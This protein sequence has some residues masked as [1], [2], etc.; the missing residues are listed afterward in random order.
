MGERHLDAIYLLDLDIFRKNRN[1]AISGGENRNFWDISIKIVY[2]YCISCEKH[3]YNVYLTEKPQER[4]PYESHNR[5][6]SQ[7]L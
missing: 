3:E 7:I 5:F 6:S 1:F 2:L 4:S